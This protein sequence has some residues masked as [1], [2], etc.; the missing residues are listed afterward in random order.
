MT[1]FV[2]PQTA[3]AQALTVT[4]VDALHDT[5]STLIDGVSAFVYVKAGASLAADDVVALTT[6]NGVVET[7]AGTGYTVPLDVPADEYFWVRK[8]A[9]LI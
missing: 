4:S 1:K 3:A 9:P 6:V 2:T 5:G 8:T 7:T